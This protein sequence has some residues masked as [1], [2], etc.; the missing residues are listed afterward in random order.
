MERGDLLSI[1]Q[2]VKEL[3]Q[4]LNLSQ[5]K[6][7]KAL[8]ISN[9]YIAGIELGHNK[10]N[11]R[12]IK[13]ICYTFLVSDRWLRTGD[14]SMFEEQPNQLAELASA[15]FKELK[16]EYQDYILKQINLL[17][18]IQRKENDKQ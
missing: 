18:D 10:V 2:R 13:L 14:G 7:A 1:N 17:L 15:T 4:S 3:R 16:P 11:D 9:S 5:A 12:L 6:F 8:S